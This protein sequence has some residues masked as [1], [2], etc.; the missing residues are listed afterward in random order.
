MQKM[1]V[2]KYSAVNSNPLWFT[3]ENTDS[4]FH[5][6]FTRC[7]GQAEDPARSSGGEEFRM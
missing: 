3:M 6:N 4:V 7:R 5:L 1:L 2:C